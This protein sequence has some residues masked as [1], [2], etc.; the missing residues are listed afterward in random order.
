MFSLCIVSC[1]YRVSPFVVFAFISMIPGPGLLLM[2]LGVPEESLVPCLFWIRMAMHKWISFVQ[3]ANTSRG[4]FQPGI[5]HACI[6]LRLRLLEEFTSFGAPKV[7]AGANLDTN[8]DCSLHRVGT[9]WTRHIRLKQL[10]R[11]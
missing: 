3:M 8:A 2:S 11:H 6:V 7:D 9:T 1:I 5:L 4:S 10:L